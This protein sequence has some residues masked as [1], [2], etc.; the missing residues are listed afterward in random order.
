M[1]LSLHA[2][3]SAQFHFLI[4]HSIRW[5]FRWFCAL[6]LLGHTVG[7]SHSSRGWCLWNVWVDVRLPKWSFALFFFLYFEENFFHPS[8]QTK[9]NCLKMRILLFKSV[10]IRLKH[11]EYA[12]KAV[13]KYSSHTEWTHWKRTT[14]W[15][16]YNLV[17]LRFN[18]C[19]FYSHLSRRFIYL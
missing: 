6:V 4:R 10:N 3:L 1:F 11:K 2:C 12:M 14:G 13:Y 15:L 18:S 16:I 17:V 9:Y 8:S 7:V 19:D 5:L